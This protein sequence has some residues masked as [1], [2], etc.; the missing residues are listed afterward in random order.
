MF[1][2]YG[3]KDAVAHPEYN[4][5][6]Y[7]REPLVDALDEAEAAKFLTTYPETSSTRKRRPSPGEQK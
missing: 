2:P 4:D 5:F 3:Q 7:W 1:P 6:S